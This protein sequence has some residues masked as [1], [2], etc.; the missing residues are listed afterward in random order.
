MLLS[1]GSPS[2]RAPAKRVRGR[3]RRRG[4]S[5]P[6][7]SVKWAIFWAVEDVGPYKGISLIRR[8][9]SRRL[10]R[11]ARDIGE[12]NDISGCQYPLAFPAGEGGSRSESD[13]GFFK[14]NST[15]LF[16]RF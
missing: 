1:Q 15:F 10:R 11:S 16:S 3:Y 12:I 7:I 14:D 2:G 5:P 9:D 13:E 8:G 6:V 4:V